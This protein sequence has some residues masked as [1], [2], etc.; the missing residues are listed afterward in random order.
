M[1][2]EKKVEYPSYLVVK[3]C[4]T[5]KTD[6]RVIKGKIIAV[7]SLEYGVKPL[8]SGYDLSLGN[9]LGVYLNFE[10]GFE[11]YLGVFFIFIFFY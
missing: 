7:L 2:L 4:R 10:V 11:F 9:F 3:F 6:L 5:T 8:V 1:K